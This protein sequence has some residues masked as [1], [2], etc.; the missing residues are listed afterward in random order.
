M[1]SIKVHIPCRAALTR[2]S[3]A[4]N[5]KKWQTMSHNV[6]LFAMFWHSSL[7]LISFS[8]LSF[9]LCARHS[10]GNIDPRTAERSRPSVAASLWSSLPHVDRHRAVQMSDSVKRERLVMK[11]AEIIVNTLR[12]VRRFEKSS[13]SDVGKMATFMR[14]YGNLFYYLTDLFTV[15]RTQLVRA[16]VLTKF[17][18]LQD[19][20]SAMNG[21]CSRI[22]AVLI[23]ERCPRTFCLI[24]SAKFH[25]FLFFYDISIACGILQLTRA[26]R[27]SLEACPCV[28]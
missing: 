28:C 2:L 13:V 8:L 16:S 11:F 3:L 1:V 17:M 18:T 26:A 14:N 10:S 24:R 21:A 22:E 19:A 20:R 25:I 12:N 4:Q 7:S 27:R 23:A 6:T 5:D 9:S 15:S